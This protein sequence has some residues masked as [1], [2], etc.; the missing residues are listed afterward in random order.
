[1]VGY[2]GNLAIGNDVE[3]AVKAAERSFAQGHGIDR[4]SHPRQ[5]DYIAHV[6]LV[7]H[8]DQNAVEHVFHNGLRCQADSHASDP[9]A[10]QKRSQVEMENILHN[11]Q[12]GQERYDDYSGGAD[13]RSKCAQL[14]AAHNSESVAPF[15]EL[16]HPAGN[17]ID[18]DD[19]RPGIEPDEQ[20]FGQAGVEEFLHIG[21][22]FLIQTANKRRCWFRPI[23]VGDEGEKGGVH[24][25]PM[26]VLERWMV[27][28]IVA[29][30]LIATPSG[31]RGQSPSPAPSRPPSTDSQKA[32]PDQAAEDKATAD[33]DPSEKPAAD[34]ATSDP[35][36][37][38]QAGG[39]KATADQDPSDKPAADQATS[40]QAAPDKPAADQ[41]T[42]DQDPSD[43]PVADQATSDPAAPDK[44][45]A[46]QVTAD[47]DPSDKPAA[48]QAT[49]DPAAPD[50]PVADEATADKDPSDKPAADQATS[51]PA[52]PDKPVADEATA[53]KDPSDKPAADQATSD[54]A[55]P[56]KPVAD[57][58]TA[59]QDTPDKPA[60]NPA[61]SDQ[62]TPDKPA[63]N[64]V[65]S[66]QAKPAPPA[67]PPPP[68][69][70]EEQQL[71]KDSD[72][73]LQLVQE[74]KAE[75]EKAGSNTLSLAALRK[76]DEIQKLS[77][78]LKER[79]KE[80][81]ASQ[82]KGQ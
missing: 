17:E 32:Q 27:A 21:E 57:Q 72:H 13:D 25:H 82:S 33:Q 81:L 11:L 76:A 53:D 23:E 77:K 44:P 22:P 35:A 5:G 78:S 20:Q 9:R 1:L 40:D 73:L 59:E 67:P 38:D 24:W 15:R 69:T 12:D 80:G 54:Q 51:D 50:K 41:A 65:S 18:Q 2:I 79:M 37:P 74:L 62:A 30:G 64:L 58:A 10:G 45:A 29:F 43:K 19:E 16:Y 28:A 52:A 36:A 75:V 8:Q 61:T 4:A 68:G 70:P 26:M 66:D 42:A 49:S 31:A 39:D 71:R 6:V 7:L 60:A 46:D 63:A 14:G 55:A 47:Q 3:R 56:E 48:D 34:Q